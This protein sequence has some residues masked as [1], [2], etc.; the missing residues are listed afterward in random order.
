MIVLDTNVVSEAMRPSPSPQVLAWLDQQAAETLHLTAVNLA[1]L[2]VGLELLPQGKRK[3]GL[4]AA[5]AGL[6]DELFGGRVL[7]FDEQ[8]AKHYAG[9][10]GNGHRAGTTIGVADGQIAAIAAAHGF[11][12]ATRGRGGFEGAGI[13]VIDP[14]QA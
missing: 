9:I 11:A 6:L 14:W 5:L 13:A 10:I 7:A 4:D 12:V 8:A 2:L 1:E 3:P